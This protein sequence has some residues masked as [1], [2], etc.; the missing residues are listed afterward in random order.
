MKGLTNIFRKIFPKQKKK[1]HLYNL[2]VDCFSNRQCSFVTKT[3]HAERAGALAVIITDNDISNTDNQ[4]DMVQDGTD[5]DIA[6]P[7]LFLLG[8]DGSVLHL[9]VRI[10]T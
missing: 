1:K 9:G 4:I 2:C 8:K 6:I 10:C 5:R 7:S 3:Y